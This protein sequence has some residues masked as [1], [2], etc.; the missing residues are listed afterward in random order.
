M[1][2]LR[3][4]EGRGSECRRR[5]VWTSL[6]TEEGQPEDGLPAVAQPLDAAEEVDI[7]DVNVDSAR[8][9]TEAF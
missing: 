2:G 1:K 3:R 5:L 4:T 6:K 9:V 8:E 7:V